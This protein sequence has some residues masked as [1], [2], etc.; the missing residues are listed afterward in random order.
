[1]INLEYEDKPI[2]NQSS[3]QELLVRQ[4]EGES[5]FPKLF[6][7]FQD[8]SPRLLSE[9]GAGIETRNVEGTYDAIHQL[10]GS[11]A[12]MGASRLFE[13]TQGAL[14]YASDERVFDI[15]SLLERIREEVNAYE[16]A[17]AA[18]LSDL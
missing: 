6:E 4:S 18:M 12:A 1:M 3:V 14:E 2:I 16:A 10:K 13:L 8:E 9:I 11:A 17:V 7:I 5:L 15:P